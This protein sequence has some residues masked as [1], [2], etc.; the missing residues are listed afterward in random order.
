MAKSP[1]SPLKLSASGVE[2]WKADVTLG[3]LIYRLRQ[4]KDIADET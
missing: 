1:S 2:F 3:N 4:S